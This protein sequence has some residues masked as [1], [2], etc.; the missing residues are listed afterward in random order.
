MKQKKPRDECR[1][2]NNEKFNEHKN[3][4]KLE[5]SDDKGKKQKIY[6]T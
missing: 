6:V 1:R 3:N 4:I 5:A 2:G